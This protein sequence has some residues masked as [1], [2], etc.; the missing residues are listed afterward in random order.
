MPPF[1]LSRRDALH[2]ATAASLSTLPLPYADGTAHAQAAGTGRV[3]RYGISMA[4]IPQTTG[5]PDRGVHLDPHPGGA[6]GSSLGQPQPGPFPERE[7]LGVGHGLRLRA[8]VEG[9]L[10]G[11][12]EM[13]VVDLGGARRGAGVAA[14]L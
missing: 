3:L 6:H 8:P 2:V 9:T 12:R 13:I 14:G 4:D 10:G 7:E 5:Q 11:G 1:P